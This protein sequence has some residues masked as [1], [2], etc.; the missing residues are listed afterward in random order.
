MLRFVSTANI[1]QLWELNL[2]TAVWT[3]CEMKGEIPE[4]LASHTAVRHP[5]QPDTMLVYGGTGA[6]FGFTTS[7]TVRLESCTVEFN[8]LL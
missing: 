7:N 1:S 8:N 3:K 5:L 2:S 6:P 4:Q